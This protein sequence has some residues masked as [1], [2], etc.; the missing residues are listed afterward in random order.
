MSARRAVLQGAPEV[1]PEHR[2]ERQHRADNPGLLR[3]ERAP[4][5]ASHLPPELRELVRKSQV[6]GCLQSRGDLDDCFHLSQ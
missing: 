6:P 1:R 4:E 5:D 2:H 3:R